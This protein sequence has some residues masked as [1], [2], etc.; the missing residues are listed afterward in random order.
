MSP[1]SRHLVDNRF[2]AP[3]SGELHVFGRIMR[4]PW[5]SDGVCKF[6]FP[7]IC[8][9]VSRAYYNH[10]I[11]RYLTFYLST[12]SLGPA[13]YL[14][15]AS[16]FHTVVITDIPILKLASK[17]QA[18]RFISLIDA[19]YET[20]CRLVC[21]AESAPQNLFFPD[22]LQQGGDV[23]M[24]SIM[25]ESVT[26]T[27]DIYRPNVAAY[28]APKMAEAPVAPSTALP[29]DTLSIFSGTSAHMSAKA[30]NTNSQPR[31]MYP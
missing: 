23:P 11:S 30:V 26:E 10:G 17:N 7:E 28:D 4:V 29:L 1:R 18:R 24:D 22:A 2:A 15:L 12:Q 5:L 31:L 19:L 20:R 13:D 25:A 27:Q 21:L 14:T 8:E 16:N 9:E 6:T 3:T